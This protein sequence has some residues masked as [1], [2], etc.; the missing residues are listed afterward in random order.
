MDRIIEVKV[1]G[2]YLTKD[3]Q[4]AGTQGESN[5]TGLRIE[6]DD[7]W[8]GFTKT[9]T[10]Y[11]AKGENPTPVILTAEKLEDITAS[12]RTYLT[13][14]PGAPLAI[15]GKCQFVIDGYINGRRQKSAYGELVVK[16]D[17]SGVETTI[18]DP[19]PSQ[20]EQLQTQ[21]DTIM[22]DMA[23][24]VTQA[25]KAAADADMSAQAAALSESHAADHAQRSNEALRGA[26]AAQG[27]A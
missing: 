19:T 3:S 17:P 20:A 22:E 18:S 4:T 25:Q 9:I 27:A 11:D 14:I 2:T 26:Q 10:W 13:L 16:P 7:G 24:Q 21:I 12:T 15:A 5:I 8:D 6:F 1:N 23:D